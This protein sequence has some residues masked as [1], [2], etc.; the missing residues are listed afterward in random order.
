MR[1]KLV[2]SKPGLSPLKSVL[3]PSHKRGNRPGFHFQANHTQLVNGTWPLVKCS[4]PFP[5]IKL[6]HFVAQPYKLVVYLL[7]M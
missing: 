1:K 2:N 5:D 7:E 4:L 6:V 3:I